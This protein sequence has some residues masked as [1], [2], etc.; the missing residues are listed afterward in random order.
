MQLGVIADDFTGATDI[1]SFLV[2][3]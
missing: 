1:A 3:N 2:R